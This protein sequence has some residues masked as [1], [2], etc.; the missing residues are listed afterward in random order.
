M[1]WNIVC[2]LYIIIYNIYI[3]IYIY[4]YI[5]IYIYILCTYVHLQ[6]VI[7]SVMWWYRDISENM[8]DAIRHSAA[9]GQVIHKRPKCDPRPIEGDVKI[10]EVSGQRWHCCSWVAEG[11]QFYQSSSLFDR[12]LVCTHTIRLVIVCMYVHTRSTSIKKLAKSGNTRSAPKYV[13][14]EFEKAGLLE[15][16]RQLGGENHRSAKLLD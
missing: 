5:S 4:I 6:T 3:Y 16:L 11:L 2:D 14:L 12:N 15:H 7:A 8:S 13:T 9:I 1:L 10:W